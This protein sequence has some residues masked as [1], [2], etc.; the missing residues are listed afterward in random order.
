MAGLEAREYPVSPTTPPP[1][2]VMPERSAHAP[3]PGTVIFSHYSRCFGCGRDHPTGLMMETVA[4]EGL[5]V[6]GE[7]K[8]T[9]HHQG[10]PGIAHGGLLAAA[11][12][13]ALGSLNWILNIPAVTARLETDFIQPIAVGSL[14]HIDAEVAGQVRRKIYT[15]A[16]G[17]LDG[18]D[19]PVAL[20]ASALFIQVP[21]EHFSSNGR[22]EDVARARA[23][24]EG[25]GP[26][27]QH[28][29]V[30]P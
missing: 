21:I 30:S 28:L 22:A 15:R 4:G 25:A 5:S 26:M 2:A 13:E 20:T 12:D 10:A 17:R 1:N 8:V 9:E 24:R 27:T 19:G 11:F 23:E 6:S 3:A 14:L 16:V 7:F 29:D 18:P